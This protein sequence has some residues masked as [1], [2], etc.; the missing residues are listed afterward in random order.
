MRGSV[1]LLHSDHRSGPLRLPVTRRAA[2]V[3]LYREREWRPP[4]PSRLLHPLLSLAV[5]SPRPLGRGAT[6]LLPR[7]SGT[8]GRSGL[9][10]TRRATHGM[11]GPPPSPSASR[12]RRAGCGRRSPSSARRRRAR[13]ARTSRPRAARCRSGPRCCRRHVDG[14]GEHQSRRAIEDEVAPGVADDLAAADLRDAERATDD[15]VDLDRLR[16]A[17]AGPEPAPHAGGI[18]PRVVDLRRWSGQR[19]LD[20]DGDGPHAFVHARFPP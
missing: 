20:D 9:S 19:L 18:E 11:R 5:R 8:G 16:F 12:T 4:S 13:G 7:A 14:P 17:E 1:P 10:A 15:G 3:G 2:R 6:V